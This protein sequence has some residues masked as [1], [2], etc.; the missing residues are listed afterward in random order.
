MCMVPQQPP[1]GPE[2][3]EPGQE[4]GQGGAEADAV[5]AAAAT[6]TP[7]DA[8]AGAADAAAGAADAAAG[9]ADAA[10]GAAPGRARGQDADVQAWWRRHRAAAAAVAEGRT[11]A[12]AP[13]HGETA[14]CSA[15]PRDVERVEGHCLRF[16]AELLELDVLQRMGRS[17][18]Q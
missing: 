10:A 2:E 5:A 11:E 3:P 18:G 6:D 7:A 4:P 17:M 8:A 14:S 12:N 13:V 9:A 15:V 1:H 16:L